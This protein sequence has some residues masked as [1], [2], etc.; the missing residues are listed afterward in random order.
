MVVLG[1]MIMKRKISIMKISH[2]QTKILKMSLILYCGA[3]PGSSILITVVPLPATTM[4]AA[5]S[6]TTL[7]V[8]G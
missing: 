3:V 2:I 4:T 7:T 5:S 1:L 8:F 6:A